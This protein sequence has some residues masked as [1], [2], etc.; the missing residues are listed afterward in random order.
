MGLSAPFA[1]YKNKQLF[2]NM[3]LQQTNLLCK[4]KKLQGINPMGLVPPC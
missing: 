1:D 4:T 3:K 2:T